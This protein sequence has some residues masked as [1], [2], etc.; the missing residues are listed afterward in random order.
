MTAWREKLFVNHCNELER[1]CAR[2]LN[3]DLNL[4]ICY[5]TIVIVYEIVDYL[6]MK[7][8]ALQFDY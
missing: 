2:Q 4:N 7:C 5:N 1:Y 8:V 3:R 6:F